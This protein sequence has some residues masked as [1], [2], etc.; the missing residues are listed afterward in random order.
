VTL[1]ECLVELQMVGE[2]KGNYASRL[3]DALDVL[4]RHRRGSETIRIEDQKKQ[5]PGSPDSEAPPERQHPHS[6]GML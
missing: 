5:T 1:A 4:S 3:N 6:I 2:E